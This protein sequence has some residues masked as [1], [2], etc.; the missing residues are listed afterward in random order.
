[1]IYGKMYMIRVEEA[2]SFVYGDGEPINP[3]EREMTDGFAYTETPDYTPINIMSLDDPTIE[4]VGV[5][6]NGECIGASKVEELPLQILAF[7]GN[8]DKTAK[9]DITFAFYYGDKKFEQTNEFA[10]YD[11]NTAAYT[12]TDIELK[13]YQAQTIRFGKPEDI[14]ITSCRMTN[15]PNPFNPATEIHYSIPEASMI[16]LN[17]YNLKGQKVKTLI[18]GK[19]EAGFH[20]I[21]WNGTDEN[22][23]S[24]SSGVYFYRLQTDKETVTRK[25]LLL[26]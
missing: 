9:N 14:P 24:V 1:M 2:C 23:N 26:K 5:Y 19:T 25:M 20:K 22:N 18:N 13:P 12:S 15:Y 16:K 11:V 6:N 3:K 10:V 4:E 17:I 21:T 7:N 8:S